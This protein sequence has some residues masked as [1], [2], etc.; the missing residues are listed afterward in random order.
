MWCFS[1]PRVWELRESHT[2][3]RSTK[4]S[5]FGY[6]R[7]KKTEIPLHFQKVEMALFHRKNNV[8]YHKA[9]ELT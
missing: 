5:L 9:P 7:D 3:E 1:E 4:R 2:E 8:L 6:R